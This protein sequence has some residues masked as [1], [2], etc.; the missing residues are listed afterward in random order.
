MVPP[1]RSFKRTSSW[2][3]FG[4]VD[5]FRTL[6]KGWGSW[7][8]RSPFTRHQTWEQCDSTVDAKEFEGAVERTDIKLTTSKVGPPSF[9]CQHLK[10]CFFF[11]AVLDVL[12]FLD[13][14]CFFPKVLGVFFAEKSQHHT[15]RERSM[16]TMRWVDA[17]TSYTRTLG[18]AFSHMHRLAGRG[19]SPCTWMTLVMPWCCALENKL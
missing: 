14:L 8:L 1:W 9:W 10:K 3:L 11:G 19:G 16:T 6:G 5:F 4:A 12:H 15:A 2:L 17:P 13:F 7:G 18:D